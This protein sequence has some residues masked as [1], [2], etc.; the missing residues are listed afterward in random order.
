MPVTANNSP[1]VPARP[2]VEHAHRQPPAHIHALHKKLE[3]S[4]ED[5]DILDLASP[6]VS[7]YY[8]SG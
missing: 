6:D 3:A 5:V 8:C 4:L 1:E 2:P 7:H